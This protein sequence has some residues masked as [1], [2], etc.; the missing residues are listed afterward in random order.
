MGAY[1][2]RYGYVC[3]FNHFDR[4]GMYSTSTKELSYS[5]LCVLESLTLNKSK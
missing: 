1:D 3:Y 4:N 5:L 2:I